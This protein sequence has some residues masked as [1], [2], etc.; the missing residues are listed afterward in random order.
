MKKYLKWS[1]ILLFIIFL[2]LQFTSPPRINPPIDEKQTLEAIKKT[3]SDV[4]AIF[5]RS[6]N[7]CHSNQTKWL[8]YTHI[9]PVS[10]F[11]TQHVNEGRAELNFSEWGTY[12]ERMRES[13]LKA[14]CSLVENGAMPLDSYLWAHSEAKLSAKD[15]K[16]ICDWSE[17]KLD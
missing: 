9:A 12:N 14:I 5:A 17:E 7:D 8:W 1:I 3:P 16:I 10:W 15:I 6:C 2:G 13:R 11:T 4:S